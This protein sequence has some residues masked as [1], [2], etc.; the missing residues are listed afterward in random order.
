MYFK[1]IFLLQIIFFITVSCGKSKTT[2][3]EI[4]IVYEENQMLFKKKSKR[5]T[6]LVFEYYNDKQPKVEINVVNGLKDGIFRQYYENGKL[7]VESK[8]KK[9]KP[10]LN[11]SKVC[12]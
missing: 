7:Q 2:L 6:G 12:N 9:G 5:F 4:D 11:I 3:S 10:T 8:F 1:R